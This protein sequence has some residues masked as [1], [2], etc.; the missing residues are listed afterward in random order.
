MTVP[1]GLFRFFSLFSLSPF[2]F[3]LPLL[4]HAAD[5]TKTALRPFHYSIHIQRTEERAKGRGVDFRLQGLRPLIARRRERMRRPEESQCGAYSSLTHTHAHKQYTHTHI[6]TERN[7][8]SE[9]DR[10]EQT[11]RDGKNFFRRERK[12]PFSHPRFTLVGL[13]PLRPALAML[14]RP[15]RPG[16]FAAALLPAPRFACGRLL[17]LAD[18]SISGVRDCH[19][20][21]RVVV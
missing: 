3:L 16:L 21:Q 13:P 5:V 4:L 18:G 14:R 6:H 11:K 9:R 1:C 8:G 20:S 19:H 10:E 12:E 2:F 7:R 15:R 17:P